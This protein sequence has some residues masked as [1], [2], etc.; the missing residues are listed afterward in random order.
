MIK[1]NFKMKK[2]II[3]ITLDEEKSG[4]DVLAPTIAEF[5]K[6]ATVSLYATTDKNNLFA[7]GSFSLGLSFQFQFFS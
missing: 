5:D 6:D 7:F 4:T 1:D 2:P 3:G